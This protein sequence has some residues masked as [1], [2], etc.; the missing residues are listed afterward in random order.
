MTAPSNIILLTF[1]SRRVRFLPTYELLLCQ[2]LREAGFCDRV[3][4]Y[5]LLD[6]ERVEDYLDRWAEADLVLCWENIATKAP[7]FVKQ[8]FRQVPR[9]QRRL[10][11]PVWFGGYWA[12]CYGRDFEE[13]ACFDRIVEGYDL[14]KVVELLRTGGPAGERFLDARGPSRYGQY[15]LDPSFL[16]TPDAYVHQRVLHGYVSSF[17]CPNNCYFCSANA[18]RNAGSGFAARKLPQVKQ[19]LDALIDAFDFD[20]LVIKDLNLFYDPDRALDILR[21]LRQKGKRTQINLD[22]TIKD[23]D[24]EVLKQLRDLDVADMLYFGLES[25]DPQTRH[26]LN[27]TYSNEQLDRAFD[28]T[29]ELELAF[30]G[31]V[32]CALP[33]QD[34]DDVDREIVQA[35]RYMERY[36][37]VFVV[38]CPYT[39]EYGTDL[40]RQHYPGIYKGMSIDDVIDVYLTDVKPFQNRL[41]GDRFRSLNLEQL[42]YAMRLINNLRYFAWR[43]QGTGFQRRVCV[44]LAE[45]LK[46][47]VRPPYFRSGLVKLALKPAFA[48]WLL[49]TGIPILA[50]P[51]SKWITRAPLL[52]TRLAIE[53]GRRVIRKLWRTGRS[54]EGMI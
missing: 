2:A 50:A 13:F 37:N 54:R 1:R 36:P 47:Q 31:N 40:Q 14:D 16:A 6:D 3:E 23:L 46:R 26:R 38:F 20:G 21:Y 11:V 12:T 28:L 7:A 17:A 32:I 24:E 4:L 5:T 25:F 39:P 41:Y 30:T 27:K 9:L 10:S 44:K 22:I 15:R 34:V 52:A 51:P 49:S 45:I 48:M 29:A 18:M 19:D 8:Y 42:A 33:W 35:L 53:K 43:G